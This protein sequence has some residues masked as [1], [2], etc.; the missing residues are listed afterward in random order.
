MR[1]ADAGKALMVALVWSLLGLMSFRGASAAHS[2]PA[3]VC[4]TVVEPVF[5]GAVMPLERHRARTMLENGVDVIVIPD[6]N[7]CGLPPSKTPG[8]LRFSF[9]LRKYGEGPDHADWT[10]ALQLRELVTD[11]ANSY[12]LSCLKCS[13]EDVVMDFFHGM[14]RAFVR[15]TPINR[16]P[17]R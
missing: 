9:E 14:A 6:K 8:L 17:S 13:V 11:R 10:I 7:N 2:P 12:E 3:S 16:S 1:Y 4:Y 15:S 5:N